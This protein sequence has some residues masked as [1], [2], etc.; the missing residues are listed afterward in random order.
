MDLMM[1]KREM[2]EKFEILKLDKMFFF[3]FASERRH[4]VVHSTARRSHR[5]WHSMQISTAHSHIVKIGPM[6]K[7]LRSA[8]FPLF[9]SSFIVG[10]S[11]TVSVDIS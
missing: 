3:V 8:D 6:W 11:M 10:S 4:Q 9:L 1:T 2:G 7:N 5:N